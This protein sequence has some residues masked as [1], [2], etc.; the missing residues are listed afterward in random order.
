MLAGTLY[1]ENYLALIDG[2]WL[3]LHSSSQYCSSFSSILLNVIQHSSVSSSIHRDNHTLDDNHILDLE[4]IFYS[5]SL[6]SVINYSSRYPSDHFPIY[7]PFSANLTYSSP[8]LSQFSF[9]CFKSISVS[10]FT[11]NILHSRLITH[12]PQNFSD[13]VVA[14]NMSLSSLINKPAPLKTTNIWTTPIKKWF[15]SAL[16]NLES[17]DDNH[18]Y[19]LSSLLDDTSKNFGYA[20]F[21]KPS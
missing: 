20:L 19:L 14:Y 18:S 11:H 2:N 6:N 17:D 12:P 3:H 4:I 1:I 13:L 16:S 5:T 7:F 15:T 9:R 8:P 21:A 10:K